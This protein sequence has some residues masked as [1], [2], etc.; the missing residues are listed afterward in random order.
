LT[1][2]G[3][4]ELERLEEVSPYPYPAGG[5]DQLDWIIG[6][7]GEQNRAEHLLA[8]VKVMCGKPFEYRSIPAAQL[9][10]DNW[11]GPGVG[12]YKSVDSEIER[13][14]KKFNTMQLRSSADLRAAQR[15]YGHHRVEERKLVI[16]I[17]E[18]RSTTSAETTRIKARLALADL[19]CMGAVR[20]NFSGT[21]ALDV[22][23]FVAS[24][25]AGR[26]GRL[27][28]L[29]VAGAY[30]HGKPLQP[31]EGGRVL[32][33]PVPPG[34]EQFGY[35]EKGENGEKNYFAVTGN[36][37]G[38]QDAGLIWQECN[39]EFLFGFG[40]E[41]SV[42]DTRCFFIH[43]GSG[44]I[45]ICIFVD[46]SFIWCSCDELWEEFYAAW[47]ERF[48]P[49]EEGLKGARAAASMAVA[50]LEF[51]GLTIERAA[52]GL[53]RFSCGKLVV[54]LERKLLEH[55]PVAEA[56][57][58]IK[59]GGIAELREPASAGDALITDEVMVDAAMS[60]VG[61]GGWIA[62]ACRAD[63]LLGFIALAQQMA[64]NFK[65]TTWRAVQRWAWCIVGSARDMVT[66]V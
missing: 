34:F 3:G 52:D 20:D 32:F 18:K 50:D 37:P 5:R 33:A 43:R 17:A 51:C 39:D 40:F 41:Q 59:L 30:L 22:I 54:D 48:P 8:E 36:L 11:G 55:G 47:S 62:Q 38:R 15:K 35:K 29:D 23:R 7:A 57:T 31:D 1:M 46:D 25:T 21:V 45:I 2:R 16:V 6:R 10:E 56:K 14:V 13:V 12:I 64:C 53:I 27:Y 4:V 26:R 60:I 28:T 19:V 44:T 65:R 9:D 58:P 61:L 49:S 63:A 66:M 24:V 42:V